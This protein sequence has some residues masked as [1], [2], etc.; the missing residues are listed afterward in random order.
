MYEEGGERKEALVKVRLCK[1]CAE[2]LCW[3]PGDERG[4]SGGR[5]EVDG[6]DDHEQKDEAEAEHDV[7]R[8]R[9]G[10]RIGDGSGRETGSDGRRRHGAAEVGRQ[11]RSEPRTRRDKMDRADARR[12]EDRHVFSKDDQHAWD[13]RTVHRPR[14]TSPRRRSRH[15][16]S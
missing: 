6:E 11:H 14:S 3:K 16:E 12:N 10:N 13:D 8:S 15:A 7:N 2:K 4:G 5:A 1:R 9:E